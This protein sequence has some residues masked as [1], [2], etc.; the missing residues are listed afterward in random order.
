MKCINGLCEECGPKLLITKYN[1]ILEQYTNENIIWNKWEYINIKKGDQLKRIVSCVSKETKVAELLAA[2]EDDL[3]N[4][5]L[6]LFSAEWQQKQIKQC[7]DKLSQG[8]I[9]LS[10]DYAESYQCR[11]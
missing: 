4:L 9:V 1:N 8:K 10:M 3:K 11:F 2:Y 6:H 7:I 5:K